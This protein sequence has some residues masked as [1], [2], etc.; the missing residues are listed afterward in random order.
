MPI[1][2]ECTFYHRLYSVVILFRRINIILI[3]T[4]YTLLYII[5]YYNIQNIVLFREQVNN[6]SMSKIKPN[7][8]E[9]CSYHF[10]IGIGSFISMFDITIIFFTKL[11]VYTIYT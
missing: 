3:Y 1:D 11:N 5:L 2:I 4:Y 7:K 10:F 8:S 9:M 6:Y